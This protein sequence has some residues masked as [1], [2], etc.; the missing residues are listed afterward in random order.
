M[1]LISALWAFNALVTLFAAHIF[2]LTDKYITEGV[3]DME[4]I[5]IA[6]GKR[7]ETRPMSFAKLRDPR[8]KRSQYKSTPSTENT[9]QTSLKATTFV[10]NGKDRTSFGR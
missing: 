8:K 4:M 6:L 10:P 7:I 3:Q 5:H 1:R 9:N 2:P